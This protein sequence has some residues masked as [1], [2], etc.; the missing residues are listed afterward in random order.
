[1]VKLGYKISPENWCLICS[2]ILKTDYNTGL[3]SVSLMV[4]APAFIAEGQV[5]G[6]PSEHS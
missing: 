4:S 6:D 3:L 2:V 1:M 5:P